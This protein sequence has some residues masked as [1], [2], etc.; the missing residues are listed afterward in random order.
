M[1]HQI[2]TDLLNHLK[3]EL[4]SLQGGTTF[5]IGQIS[6]EVEG[7][8]GLGGLIEEWFGRWAEANNYAVFDPKKLGNS[9]KFPDYYVGHQQEGLLEIKSFD[10]DA[11]ANFDIANFESYC[12]SLSYNPNRVNSDY[13]IFGYKLEGSTLKIEN[14]WLKKIWEITCPSQRWPLKTQTKRDVIYN[15]RPAAWH[16]NNTRFDVFSS[17]NDFVNAL[18]QTQKQYLNISESNDELRYRQATRT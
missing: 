7:K 3:R 12:E 2:S 17:K 5:N 10:T 8:D 18:Y 13:L 4:P 11:S 9:Q 15:I 16:K 14:V 1:Y 6:I